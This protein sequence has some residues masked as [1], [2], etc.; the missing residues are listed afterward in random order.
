MSRIYK[1]TGIIVS[2][3]LLLSQITYAENTIVTRNPYYSP[4]YNSRYNN[5]HYKHNMENMKA[6]EKYAFN[7]SFTGDSYIQ[8]LERLE[9]Q[10][11][12]SVQQGDFDSRF[13]NVRAAILSR[14]KQNYKNSI[15]KSLSNYISGQMTGFT[16]SIQDNYNIP[17]S[18]FSYFPSTYGNSVN[19]GYSNP[20]GQRYNY[21]NYGV[22]N[23]SGVRI[24]Y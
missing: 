5:Y 18:N 24:M 20:W 21:N 10:A 22:G 7:K 15:M 11:F 19:M 13:E 4:Y 8:R 16:P 9:T 2:V 12:G 3:S 23:S 1:I 14:P 17:D 6:L